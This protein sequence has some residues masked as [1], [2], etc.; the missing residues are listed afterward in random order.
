MGG[1]WCDN[2]LLYSINY[3]ID[4]ILI[5]YSPGVSQW[6][7]QEEAVSEAGSN[8]E[9]LCMAAWEMGLCVEVV[10][11]AALPNLMMH[12]CHRKI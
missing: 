1:Q 11:A 7:V 10:R 2:Y 5:G 8:R 9:A 6:E 4:Y 12:H 3:G